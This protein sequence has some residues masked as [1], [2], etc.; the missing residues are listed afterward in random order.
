M[1]TLLTAINSAH[2]IVLVAHLNPDG[3][4]VGS[5]LGLTIALESIG[6]EVVPVLHDAVPA[7]FGRIMPNTTIVVDKLPI[8][9]DLCILLDAASGNRTGFADE[10][11]ALAAKHKLAVI[12]HHP[13][14]ELRK[15]AVAYVHDLEASSTAEI[16]LSIIQ[17]LAVKITPNLATCLLTGIYTDTGGFQHSNTNERSLEAAAELMRRGGK[18]QAITRAFDQ[19]KSLAGLRLLGLALERAA[20]RHQDFCTVSC[21]SQADFEELNADDRDIPGIITQLNNLPDNRFAMLLSQMHGGIIRGS[22]RSSNSFNFNVNK[23]ARLLGG[24]GH[25]KAAGF[26]LPGRLMLQNSRWQIEEV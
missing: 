19:D 20:G 25:S 11:A 18:L 1:E 6:K 4:A 7:L 2:S 9:C 14:L 22:C 12:D 8:T 17:T 10:I 5:L 21:L 24:G 3:D 23:L 15:S 16:L 26:S 13:Q